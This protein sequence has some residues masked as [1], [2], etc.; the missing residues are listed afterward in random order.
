MD[1]S[2][3]VLKI[4]F[5]E[6]NIGN[7]SLLDHLVRQNNCNIYC[8]IIKWFSN[9]SSSPNFQSPNDLLLILNFQ[10]FGKNE[11]HNLGCVHSFAHGLDDGGPLVTK[12]RTIR[13]GFLCHKVCTF[14]RCWVNN[15]FTMYATEHVSTLHTHCDPTLTQS[16]SFWSILHVWRFSFIPWLTPLNQQLKLKWKKNSWDFTLLSL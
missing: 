8:C 5:Y 4:K 3:L 13:F 11:V 2:N 16:K 12:W 15:H 1:F 7:I 9:Q 14:L 6:Q 10:K